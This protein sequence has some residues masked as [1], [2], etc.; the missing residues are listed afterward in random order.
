[1]FN[2]KRLENQTMED[3]LNKQELTYQ[4]Q[5]L[6]KNKSYNIMKCD[7]PNDANYRS[8]KTRITRPTSG[9]ENAN[10]Q[11]R[12]LNLQSDSMTRLKATDPRA[13]E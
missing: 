4:Q 12:D 9:L 3:D 2:K 11:S 8:S 5:N 1:M 6:K 10:N 13:M 7:A